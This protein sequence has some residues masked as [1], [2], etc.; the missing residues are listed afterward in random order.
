MT[1][2]A[3]R[4]LADYRRMLKGPE[5]EEPFDV[6]LYRPLAYLVV[7]AVAPTPVT[8]NQIT[9]INLLPGLAAA[10]YF[11]RGTPDGYLIG[12]ALLFLTNVLDCADGMLARVRGA[13]SLTG[14]ILDG[15]ADYII[16]GALFTAFL[17]GIALRHG[18]PR[19]SLYLGIPAGLSA[20]WWCSRLDLLRGEWM[21]RVHGRRRDPHGELADL[22]RQ[23]VVWR[24]ERSHWLDRALVRVFALYVRLWYSGKSDRPVPSSEEPVEE[25]M[26]RRRPVLRLAVLM[27][28]ST[29]IT[30]LII[31]VLA[32]RPEWYIWTSLV[33]GTAWGL[34]V[35]ALRAVRER[36]P[37]ARRPKGYRH[38]GRAVG[39]GPGDASETADG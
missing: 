19:L 37:A 20:A 32:G 2:L 27:G 23:A 6:Y 34:S 30:L 33:F 12:A 36:R 25:W 39:C 21:T 22:E 1:S 17:H 9:A 31:A 8:P 13:G 4:W 5:L 14:Y 11:W 10:A 7:K 35:L 38:A 28:P 24:Q 3:G 16:Q 26:R 29:H 15:L 18:D